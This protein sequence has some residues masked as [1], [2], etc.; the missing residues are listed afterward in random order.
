MHNVPV[1]I[2]YFIPIRFTFSFGH[3]LKLNIGNRINTGPSTHG[4]QGRRKHLVA[5][6]K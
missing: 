5:E 4:V 6:K 3:K 2:L 1:H